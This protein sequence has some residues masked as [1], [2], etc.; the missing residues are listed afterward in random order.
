MYISGALFQDILPNLYQ[1][2]MYVA[3]YTN[4][5]LKANQHP[6]ILDVGAGT[7]MVAVEVKAYFIAIL[8]YSPMPIS[9]FKQILLL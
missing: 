7:G 2:P 5:Y 3:Q 9:A 8:F 1:G 4:K 6:R